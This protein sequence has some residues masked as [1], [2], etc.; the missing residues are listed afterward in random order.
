MQSKPD[1]WNNREQAA[2]L[3]Q[4]LS[5]LSQDISFIEDL[6]Q[7]I[8]EQKELEEM[9][10]SEHDEQAVLD[11]TRELQELEKTIS[12]RERLL[13][14]SGPYDSGNAIITIQSGAGGA[15][16]QDWASM[17]ERMYLRFAERRGWKT[18]LIDTLSFSV[19]GPYAYG[20]LKSEHGVHRLVRLSP[21]NADAK[22]Q[23]SFARV[24]IMPQ[25]KET[26]LPEI[27]PKDLEID[28][29]R[30]SGA[31]GQHVNKTSSAVRIRHIPT[32]LVTTSQSQRSQAQ[33]KEAAMSMLASRIQLLLEEQH[34]QKVKDLRGKFQEAAFGSQIRSYVLHPYTLVKDH[35]TNVED[36]NAQG[37]L[38]GDLDAFVVQ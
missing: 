30:A 21:F 20:I 22:R 25:L 17:L 11:V 31:G 10:T 38:D 7:K 32:G 36:R 16:A 15:D 5:E 35:R 27:D 34:V 19:Q 24:E 1:F 29:Y 14:F 9:A 4:E 28:T 18:S 3:T 8:A 13:K 6:E 23:T 33:N 12:Q 26:Q 2:T 37:I